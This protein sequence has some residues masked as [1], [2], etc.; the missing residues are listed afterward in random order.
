M[1]EVIGLDTTGLVS[2]ANLN[3]LSVNQRY[4]LIRLIGNGRKFRYIGIIGV[5][6]TRPEGGEPNEFLYNDCWVENE[7]V[8]YA[9]APFRIIINNSRSFEINNVTRYS[10]DNP[11]LDGNKT[12]NHKKCL[13]SQKKRNRDSRG[14]FIRSA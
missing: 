1:V 7:E 3:V 10:Y 2:Y 12:K 14:R 13:K 5:D 9:L 6:S 8:I 11:D 4:D